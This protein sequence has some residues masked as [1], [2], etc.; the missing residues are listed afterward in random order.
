[1][2]A[3]QGVKVIE[4]A[5]GMAGPWI[6]RLMAYCGAEVIRVESKKRPDVTRQYVPPW[7]PEMGMQTQLS[8]W[9]TDWNAGK[10]FVALDLTRPIAIELAKRLV[11]HGDVVVE[12]YATGVIGRLGLGYAELNQVRPEIIML[13]T[14]GFGDSGPC[15]RY[16]TWGPNIE[17]M[18]GLSTL[19]G[20][21]ERSCTITQYAYPDAVGALHGLFAVMCALDYRLRTGKGQ[22]I[23][24]SQYEATVGVI[25]HVIMEYLA[26]GR[27]PARRGNG[28][29]HAAPHG[30]YPCSGDDRW[31]V[32]TVSTAAE[33]ERL[34]HIVGQPE[35]LTDPRF[36]TLSARLEHASELD[37]LI[38]E[39][40][41]PQADY[42]VM[43][44]LQAAGI[45]AGVVQ[46]VEDQF[47][48]DP[49]LAARGF[50]EEIEHLKKGKVVAT[51]IPLGLTGTPGR[52][53]SSGAAIGQDNA[54]VFGGLLGM[55][56]R[57]IQDCIDGGVI[58][59][60]DPP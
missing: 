22:Y 30:C 47:R 51:G 4:F 8:P 13:S 37:R 11:A 24:L 6:G 14:A 18:S 34:C 35:W 52:T 48:R 46:N 29:L 53:S 17:A 26:N 43:A 60:A 42:A 50:F 58:E 21:P 38:A 7:A 41:A 55:S 57:E 32:I 23:N 54:Y 15:S 16:I 2:Q 5:Y 19:S 49:Q 20:F 28:S 59:T 25:G 36:A 39:W 44:T 56:A 12:N 27:E 31:C 3:L 1:M 10:R 9:F 40:T 45:A 33:W